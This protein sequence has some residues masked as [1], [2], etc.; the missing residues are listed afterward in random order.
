[1]SRVTYT[2]LD[3]AQGLENTISAGLESTIY[4]YV[5][6]STMG[7]AL[8]AVLIEPVTA[9]FSQLMNRGGDVWEFLVYVIVSRADMDTAI[10]QLSNFLTGEGPDSIRRAIFDNRNLG[11]GDNVQAYVYGMHGYGGSFKWYNVP[12]VGAA[13]LVRVHIN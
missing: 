11:I 13:L 7:S 12:H 3:I 6:P 5:A 1:M 9:N 10:E 4:T 2:V 8:P